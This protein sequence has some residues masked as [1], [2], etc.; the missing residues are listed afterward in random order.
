MALRLF[1]AFNRVLG[2]V[3]QVAAY[4]KG[5][6]PKISSASTQIPEEGVN[7]HY[8]LFCNVT[9][10]HKFSGERYNVLRKLGY[11]QYSTVWLAYDSR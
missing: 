5:E 6:L 4:G 7:L 10:G 11:G 3:S 8:A 2:K 1:K 9:V